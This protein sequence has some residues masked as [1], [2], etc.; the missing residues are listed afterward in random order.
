MEHLLGLTHLAP[1][2]T[3]SCDYL[4]THIRQ[5]CRPRQ[6]LRKHG[7]CFK[8]RNDGL[9]TRLLNAFHLACMQR[10]TKETHCLPFTASLTTRRAA[11]A[12][13]P[14]IWLS[15]KISLSLNT[16]NSVLLVRSAFKIL[17]Y[18]CIPQSHGNDWGSYKHEL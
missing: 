17:S 16:S 10:P 15:M 4:K 14:K 18:L 7:Q 8:L 5:G 13:R 1:F 12:T 11:W 3:K 9:L 6:R 2:R